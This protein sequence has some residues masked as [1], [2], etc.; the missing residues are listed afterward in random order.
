MIMRKVLFCIIVLGLLMCLSSLQLYAAKYITPSPVEQE[1]LSIFREFDDYYVNWQ[2]GYGSPDGWAEL[3]TKLREFQ[4]KQRNNGELGENYFLRATLVRAECHLF[5]TQAVMERTKS[6][7][8]NKNRFFADNYDRGVHALELVIR[9][10]QEDPQSA[11]KLG[12]LPNFSEMR[13]GLRLHTY[14][15]FES[16]G[17]GFSKGFNN[18]E[19]T[20]YKHRYLSLDSYL[21]FLSG[22][23]FGLIRQTPPMQIAK[24][25]LTAFCP[26][27]LDF[28]LHLKKIGFSADI[29]MRVLRA[30]AGK[31]GESFT[32]KAW[33][34]TKVLFSSSGSFVSFG[35]PPK[36]SDFLVDP[37]KVPQDVKK[38]MDIIIGA[39]SASRQSKHVDVMGNLR[40][41]GTKP[42]QWR[43][44]SDPICHLWYVSPTIWDWQEKDYLKVLILAAKAALGGASAET[45][46]SIVVDEVAPFLIS[47][48]INAARGSV[49]DE[50]VYVPFVTNIISEYFT[51]KFIRDKN[52]YKSFTGLLQA[53]EWVS[54]VDLCF[55]AISLTWD[56]FEERMNA[57]RFEG[58]D[59]K[60]FSPGKSYDGSNIPPVFMR[61]NIIGTGHILNSNTQ[62]SASTNQS[63]AKQI[64][65]N[66]PSHVN[67]VRYYAAYPKVQLKSQPGKWLGFGEYDLSGN[68]NDISF[69]AIQWK[70]VEEPL[71]SHEIITNFAP[72]RQI[73]EFTIDDKTYQRVTELAKLDPWFQNHGKSRTV[74]RFTIN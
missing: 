68:I 44:V 38:E 3:A 73:I 1:L 62:A 26:W 30:Y 2:K 66:Y 61:A 50:S 41:S 15:G 74:D 36:I 17:T 40:L 20:Y 53:R 59:P 32:E 5:A 6:R 31:L 12:M 63:G 16:V 49:S 9:S 33:K 57:Y 51:D 45:G 27:G 25:L 22:K 13:R 55:D 35:W 70:K 48:V 67:A 18:R 42:I 54:P 39:D 43:V 72:K 34:N 21:A 8:P 4:K 19:V 56:H 52:K 28:Y 37:R 23:Q 29:D 24:K 60:Q 58:I 7:F 46:L 71:S 47:P 64:T 14:A 69:K 11:Q 65:D 10:L